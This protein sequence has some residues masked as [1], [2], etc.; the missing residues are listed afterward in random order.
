MVE[1]DPSTPLMNIVNRLRWIRNNNAFKRAAAAYRGRHWNDA[2]CETSTPR[3]EQVPNP[4]EAFFRSRTTGRGVWKWNHYLDIY[5]QH[6]SRFRDSE[7][8]MVEVGVLGGGS[9]D[10]W[11]EYF[12]PK[13]S[14]FGIDINPVC[15]AYAKEG[16]KIY[17]GNQGD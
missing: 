1:L 3:A 11:R 17:I 14:L 6:F 2:L 16:V 10:M 4:L 15:S 12:G 9:L 13:V 5:H 7:I 8:N